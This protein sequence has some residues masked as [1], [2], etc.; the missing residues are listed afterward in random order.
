MQRQSQYIEIIRINF[1]SQSRQTCLLEI[2][3]W[4]LI[5]LDYLWRSCPF[6]FPLDVMQPWIPFVPF[7]ARYGSAQTL[8]SFSAGIIAA[9]KSRQKP[10]QNLTR[11]RKRVSHQLTYNKGCSS[12]TSKI[13]ITVPDVEF[14]VLNCQQKQGI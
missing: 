11:K 5:S 3:A 2:W 1:W 8:V 4:Q 7:S 10:Q 13:K 14:S 12:P 9:K 6:V